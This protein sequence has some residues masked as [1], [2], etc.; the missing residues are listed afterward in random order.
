MRYPSERDPSLVNLL[1]RAAG[2]FLL[3]AGMLIALT[4]RFGSDLTAFLSIILLALGI[5]C[6]WTLRQTWYEITPTRLRIRCG[7]S[8]MAIP[9]EEVQ[10]VSHSEDRR[11]APALSF[12]RLRI[13]Y[14]QGKRQRTVLISPQDQEGFLEEA[15]AQGLLHEEG[16]GFVRRQGVTAPPL[17]P[18]K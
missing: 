14:Q 2:F 11:T 1:R 12:R 8:R 17:S 7:P 3:G 18:T 9:W 15:C 4:L 16:D 5:A 10:R 13:E 6:L